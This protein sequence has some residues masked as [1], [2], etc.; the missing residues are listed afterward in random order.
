MNFFIDDAQKLAI[1]QGLL[2]AFALVWLI[3]VITNL[4]YY[5]R[6]S[7]RFVSPAGNHLGVWAVLVPMIGG[8]VIGLMARYGSEKIRGHGMPEAIEAIAAGSAPCF[9]SGR[10]ATRSSISPTAPAT[11]NATA[12]E[13]T[14]WKPAP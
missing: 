9:T 2:V 6:F 4:A 8:L 13:P 1:A 14:T 5:Q 11:T 10:C 12:S 7:S 3:A